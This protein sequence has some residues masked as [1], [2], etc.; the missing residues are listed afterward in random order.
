MA[1]TTDKTLM[2]V[3]LKQNSSFS[4]R[5]RQLLNCLVQ[6]PPIRPNAL[7]LINQMVIEIS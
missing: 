7:P 1:K 5:D 3:Q 4:L 2:F 6:R